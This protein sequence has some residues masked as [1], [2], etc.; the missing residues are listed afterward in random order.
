MTMW[1]P[2]KLNLRH[3]EIIRLAFLGLKQP[4]IAN[5]LG[6]HYLT[7]KLVLESPLAQAELATMID[8]ARRLAIDSPLR[9]EMATE[10]DKAAR[11]SLKW[12]AGV[13]D[14]PNAPMVVK[15]RVSKH[16][17]DRVVFDTDD[18]GTKATYREILRKV[19]EVSRAMGN[20]TFLVNP[21]PPAATE[22]ESA[23]PLALQDALVAAELLELAQEESRGSHPS[24]ATGS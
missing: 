21:S 10:L 8:Q 13:L 7:V 18:D 20:E 4:Q 19:D 23:E 17:L 5:R 11:T 2:T 15:E 14:D 9:A 6:L 3:Y 1:A 16:F 12:R 22:T 24:P